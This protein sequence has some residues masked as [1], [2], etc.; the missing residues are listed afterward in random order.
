MD[1]SDRRFEAPAR[2]REYHRAHPSAE[3][4]RLALVARLEAALTRAE[5]L[6]AAELADRLE[7]RAVRRQRKELRRTIVNE[8]LHHLVRAGQAAAHGRPE[9]ASRFEAPNPHLTDGVFLAHAWE[10]LNLARANRELLAGAGFSADQV[11]RLGLTLTWL[12]ATTERYG[13]RRRRQIGVRAELAR[14]A[15]ELAELSLA[16]DG[17]Q[18]A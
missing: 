3:P 13:A 12:E 4:S 15:A 9:L 8:L 6:A 1:T 7:G 16:L 17:E 10:L 18:A 14:L 11:E 5:D 2:V